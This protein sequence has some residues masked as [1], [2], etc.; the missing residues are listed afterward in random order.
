METHSSA[1]ICLHW[2]ALVDSDWLSGRT[3]TWT[4]LTGRS[5]F[6]PKV[7]EV[8]SLPAHL[9][10]QEGLSFF[11][12]PVFMIIYDNEK[13]AYLCTVCV[14][15]VPKCTVNSIFIF[16]FNLKKKTIRMS[17]SFYATE[18]DFR[19]FF[20]IMLIKLFLVSKLCSDQYNTNK[21]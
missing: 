6:C 20:C 17:W 14:N 7:E 3:W 1:L 19:V 21:R 18:N 5:I 8:V 13:C 16:F 10:I 4:S 9:S 11:L 15:S 2:A 12:T